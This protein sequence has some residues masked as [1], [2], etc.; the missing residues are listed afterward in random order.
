MLKFGVVVI[1]AMAVCWG[2]YKY[3]PE[4]THIAY[5]L[6]RVGTPITYMMMVGGVVTFAFWRIVS[7]K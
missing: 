5:N 2:V 7:G 1:A 6:P 4:S 3:I